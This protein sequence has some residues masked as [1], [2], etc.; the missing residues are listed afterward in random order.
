MAFFKRKYVSG[1]SV[2]EMAYIIPLFFMIFVVIIHTVFYYHDKMIMTGAA[3]ETAIVGAQSERNRG[4]DSD[5]DVFFK[6]RLEGK[7][8]YMT[9]PELQVI[10]TDNKVEAIACAEVGAMKIVIH[11]KADIVHPEKRIR[12]IK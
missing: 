6:E 5:L 1:S 3:C 12:W 2:I 4:M 7:L 11:E 10:K 9:N 8:I